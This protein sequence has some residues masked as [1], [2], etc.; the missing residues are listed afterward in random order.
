M[1]SWAASGVPRCSRRVSGGDTPRDHAIGRRRTVTRPRQLRSQRR[2]CQSGRVHGRDPHAR[3]LRSVAPLLVDGELIGPI[4]LV[5]NGARTIGATYAELLRPYVGAQ[6]TVATMLDGSELIAV[7]NWGLSRNTGLGLL[8]LVSPI[9]T[10][11]DVRPLGIGS[12]CATVDT[13][14]APAALVGVV[15]D[16]SGFA[17]TWIPVQ[18]DQDDGGG[19][20]D[21]VTRVASP[22]DDAHVGMIADGAA[23]FAWF[24]PNPALGRAGEVLVMGLAYPYRGFAQPRER[25]VLAEIVGL[26]DLGRALIAAQKTEEREPELLQVAG[27]IEDHDGAPDDHEP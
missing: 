19:M 9:D 15:R 13:R 14:G 11:L 1:E 23:L 27:E 5:R 2:S 4:I 10:G 16:G 26:D 12:V 20:S 17:R 18:I 21:V 7:G 8:E 3:E 24:P 6:F 22:L 25:P